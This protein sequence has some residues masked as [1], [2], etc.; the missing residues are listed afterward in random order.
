ML[1]NTAPVITSEPPASAAIG[2]TYSY[3]LAAGDGEGQAI[4]FG[5]LAA[6]EGMTVDSETGLLTWTPPA[7]AS[8][9]TQVIVE[10]FDTRGAVPL[11]RFTIEVA[12]G[13]R[14]PR[15]VNPP[16]RPEGAEGGLFELQPVGI[17]RRGE[18]PVGKKGG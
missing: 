4:F 13:N 3:Q 11:Q 1:P 7:D 12:N 5:L 6:P 18:R 17:A 8:A 10:A 15:L 9:L 2:E 14:A 16:L